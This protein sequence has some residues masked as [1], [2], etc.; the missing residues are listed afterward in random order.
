MLIKLYCRPHQK[1]VPWYLGTCVLYHTIATV[2]PGIAIIFLLIMQGVIQHLHMNL[3]WILGQLS[4]TG[5]Y[6]VL[7][8]VS[9]NQHSDPYI[10]KRKCCM[11]DWLCIPFRALVDCCFQAISSPILNMKTRRKNR[12]QYRPYNNQQQV[13]SLQSRQQKLI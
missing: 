7:T 11:F 1:V 2:S 8:M 3:T 12:V 10:P 6:L 13:N 5:R 4:L 9:P